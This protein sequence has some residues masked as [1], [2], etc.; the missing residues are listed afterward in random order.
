MADQ[1]KV[2][3]VICWICE[4]PIP[5]QDCQT[6]AIGHPVHEDCDLALT[7]EQRKDPNNQ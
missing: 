5:L 4:K 2:R 7:M 1:D 3:S 6:D